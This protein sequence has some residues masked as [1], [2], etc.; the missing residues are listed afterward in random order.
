M[1]N[2]RVKQRQ[3]YISMKKIE[4]IKELINKGELSADALRWKVR[5][6][7]TQ[8]EEEKLKLKGEV[9]DEN[10]EKIMASNGNLYMINKNG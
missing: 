9:K 2:E 3:R 4:A 5:R 8:S 6:Y 7:R 1:I 10:C